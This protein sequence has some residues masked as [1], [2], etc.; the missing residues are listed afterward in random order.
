MLFAQSALPSA[1]GSLHS[2]NDLDA[3]LWRLFH[4]GQACWPQI[5]VS[6]ERFAAFLGRQLQAEVADPKE[7]DSLRA[8]DLYILC[9]LRD[10]TPAAQEI[11][12]TEYM[13][14]VRRALLQL[15]TSEALILD[16]QQNLYGRLLE[17]QDDSASRLGYAGRGELGS[18]LCTCAVREAGLQHK[19]GQREVALDPTTHD[20]TSSSDKSPES[21]LLQ[22]TMKEA[23]QSALVEAI[24]TLTSRER[25]LLRYH[26]LTGLSIDEIGAIYKVHRATAARWLARAEEQLVAKTREIFVKR[27]KISADSL[28]QIVGLIQS[29]LS[30]GLKTLLGKRGA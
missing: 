12:H 25:N 19:R 29:Q 11:F 14:R 15:G 18:W 13:P 27:T 22:G 23:F 21:A 10:K 24:S 4:E 1:K 3:A 7:L 16:I 26:F 6:P 20:A 17:Q 5:P 30:V 9:A 28:P 8:R 2:P